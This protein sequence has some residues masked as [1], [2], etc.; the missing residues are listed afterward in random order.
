MQSYE[1]VLE[2]RSIFFL[3][4]RSFDPI[5]A[6]TLRL[7]ELL[8]FHHILFFSLYIALNPENFIHMMSPAQRPTFSSLLWKIHLET[9]SYLYEDFIFSK[10]SDTIASTNA[11]T[12]PLQ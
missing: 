8:H 9:A 11:I 5:Y 6:F 1:N 3:P 4:S 10:R 12:P 2:F 7:L